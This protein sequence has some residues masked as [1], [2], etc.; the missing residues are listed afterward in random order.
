MMNSPMMRRVGM[1]VWAITGLAALNMGLAVLLGW[2]FFQTDF[3]QMNMPSLVRPL[4]LLIGLS[5]LVS[6]VMFGMAVTCKCGKCDACK[7]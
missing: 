2:D 4:L 1:A 7:S 3:M 6:L 5:G